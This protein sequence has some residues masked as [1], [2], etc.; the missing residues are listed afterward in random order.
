VHLGLSDVPAEVFT[1]EDPI[2]A[3][4]KHYTSGR[5]YEDV[6]ML[7]WGALGHLHEE[8]TQWLL[9]APKG[10]VGFARLLQPPAD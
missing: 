5:R 9:E 7:V 8:L 4:I 2:H 3:V 1:T 6:D 10:E